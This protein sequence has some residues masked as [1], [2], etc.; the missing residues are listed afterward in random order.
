MLNYT[1]FTFVFHNRALL[2]SRY[3]HQAKS[4]ASALGDKNAECVFVMEPD[5][6]KI[7]LNFF[8]N[9]ICKI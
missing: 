3:Q 2:V 1:K 5:V 9:F 8:Y 4:I 7:L 6:L